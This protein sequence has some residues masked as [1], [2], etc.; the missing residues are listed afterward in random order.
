MKNPPRGDVERCAG[1]GGDKALAGSTVIVDRNGH[2]YC[3]RCGDRL[4]PYLRKTK[5]Q[6]KKVMS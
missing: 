3:K 4:P 6:K 5:P 2:R 1:W